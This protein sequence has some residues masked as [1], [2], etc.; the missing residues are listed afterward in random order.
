M[1]MQ[2]MNSCVV[3]VL[4]KARCIC[5]GCVLLLW[6]MCFDR[7]KCSELVCCIMAQY[8]EEP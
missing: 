2:R 6:S 7:V 3:M 5:G 4:Q 1:V 8:F